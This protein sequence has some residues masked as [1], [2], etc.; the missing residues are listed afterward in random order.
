MTRV[1]LLRYRNLGNRGDFFDPTENL[2]DFDWLLRAAILWGKKSRREHF[3]SLSNGDPLLTL[4]RL[5]P[6][7]DRGRG[8]TFTGWIPA[9]TPLASD[10]WLQQL[11]ARPSRSPA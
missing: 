10:P 3:F 5:F 4:E 7:I 9:G 1:Q 2:K 11:Q 6:D 8:G